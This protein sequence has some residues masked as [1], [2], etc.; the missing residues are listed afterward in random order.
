MERQ[1]GREFPRKG[2]IKRNR[3]TTEKDGRK[4]LK[5]SER[6]IRE[7]DYSSSS[8]KTTEEKEEERQ[9]RPYE[10]V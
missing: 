4:Q 2:D 6:K 10:C 5:M 8:R 9:K 7:E 3:N 1:R